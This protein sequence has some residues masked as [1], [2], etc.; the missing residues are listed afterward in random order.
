MEYRP[1]E[2]FVYA[3]SPFN[4][5]ALG[6]NLITAPLI[7]GNVVIWK[8]SEYSLYASYL[9]HE[10]LL[11]A[12]IPKDV[13]QFVPG[14][15]E[16]VTQAVV[17]HPDF[18]AVNFIGSTEVFR[19]LSGH[20]AERY[21]Q[22]KYPSYPRLVGETGGKNFHLVHSSADIES[23]VI[24][25]VRGAFEYQ[26]QKCSSTSRLYISESIWPTFRDSLLEK[27][28][29]LKVGAPQ[30]FEN[31]ITPVIHERAFDRLSTVIQ[32]AQSDS[33]LTL[34]TGGH[35]SKAEGYFIHPTIYQ[36]QDPYHDLIKRE[37]FGPILLVYVFPDEEYWSSVPHLINSATQFALTGGIFAR[38]QEAIRFARNALKHAAGN[39]YIN[40]KSTGSVVGQQ[41]FGGGRGSGT[42]D[43][44]GTLNML[45]RFSSPRVI[46]E[47][48]SIVL[49]R[50][51]YPSNEV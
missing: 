18:S 17:D 41:P 7:L 40:T 38:D 34:L 9:I 13:I 2:G 14:D 24:N 44:V 22:R 50:V 42:N 47:E 25:T 12:G 11:E 26:G 32:N 46:K 29:A 51:L 6:A 43:K 10:I 37:L 5:T 15:A 49:D 36:T 39:L 19:L 27:T 20:I 28:K 35:Y 8:P 21:S 4:F 3:V 30:Y 31:F 48:F 1:L 33:E 16:E 45:N 23:A